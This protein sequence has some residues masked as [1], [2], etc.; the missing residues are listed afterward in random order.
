MLISLLSIIIT[1]IVIT[2]SINTLINRIKQADHEREI[3]IANA[4]HADKLAS[5]GR[6]AAGVAHEIN[7]PLAIINEQ[8]GL[9]KDLLQYGDLSKNK[10][11]F[12]Q[13]IDSIQNSVIRCRTITHRLLSFSRRINIGKEDINVND[14]IEEVLGFIEKEIQSK[15]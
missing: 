3:A 11:R 5:I 1:F 10:D 13:L 6:L 7:N 14:V 15:E 2:K 12:I 4:E 9:V 8:A